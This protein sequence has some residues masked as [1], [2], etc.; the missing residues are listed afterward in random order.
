[1]KINWKAAIITGIA[2]LCIFGLV[3]WMSGT[4]VGWDKGL[5]LVSE[6]KIEPNVWQPYKAV[7]PTDST[8]IY[9]V[10][11]GDSIIYCKA[12]FK[13][14]TDGIYKLV[15][16]WL[17]VV[18]I[19]VPSTDSIFFEKVSIDSVPAEAVKRK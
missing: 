9:R 11:W 1:M 2:V 7:D 4:R 10:S 19:R 14:D 16:P 3:F 15:A 13:H 17:D 5:V 8:H 18:D 12:I 6:V